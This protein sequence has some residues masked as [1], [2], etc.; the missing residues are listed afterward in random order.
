[1]YFKQDNNAIIKVNNN[2]ILDE[3]VPIKYDRPL[4][5]EY[6]STNM[7]FDSFCTKIDLKNKIYGQNTEIIQFDTKNYLVELHP[8]VRVFDTFLQGCNSINNY[9]LFLIA[10]RNFQLVITE[11]NNLIKVINLPCNLIQL[12]LDILDD[13]IVL[14]G[15]TLYKNYLLILDNKLDILINCYFD[16][17]DITG[18]QIDIIQHNNDTLSRVK[19]TVYTYSNSIHFDKTY[20]EYKKSDS[21]NLPLLFIEAYIAKDFT[22]IKE[23]LSFD[24]NTNVLQQ[25]LQDLAIVKCPNLSQLFVTNTKGI[26]KVA[27]QLQ[28]E[29][30]NNKIDTFELV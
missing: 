7:F 28:C 8:K 30:T 9:N 27:K 13:Y 18:N 1:M 16:K 10:T 26:F 6:I 25:Y 23:Y 19:H 11:Q 15:N 24:V 22:K 17:I 2:V 14:I 29:I 20:Y 3:T 4:L 5:I 12:K 21:T